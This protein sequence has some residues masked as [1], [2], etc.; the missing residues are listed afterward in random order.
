MRLLLTTDAHLASDQVING[1]LPAERS[2]RGH[3]RGSA[4]RALSVVREE[5][6]RAM[7]EIEGG[8]AEVGLGEVGEG[9]KIRGSFGEEKI[10]VGG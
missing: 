9:E 4:N 8:E 7:G 3:G 2:G 5:E 10:T 6:D 1:H